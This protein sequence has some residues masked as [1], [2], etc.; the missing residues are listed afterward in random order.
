M[1]ARLLPRPALADRGLV[2]LV[3]LVCAL[4]TVGATGASAWLRTTAD[5]MAAEVFASAKW[6]ARQ[7][8]VTYTDVPPTTV[9]DGAATRLEDALAEPF[10]D[11]LDRPRHAAA[12]VDGLPQAL[13]RRN[14]GGPAYLSVAGIPDVRDQVRVV[15][16]RFP[17]S[18]SRLQ[19]LPRKVAAA[20]DGPRRSPVV[21]VALEQTAAENLN[22][23]TG[24]YVTVSSLRY[25]RTDERAAVLHIVGLYQADVPYPAAI[26]DVPNARRPAIS[27][28][29]EM[30]SVRAAALTAD[31]RTVL[32]TQWRGLPEVV[33]TF[34]P[35]GAPT[36]EEM[37]SLATEA[38]GLAVQPWPAVVDARSASASTGIGDLAEEFLAERGASDALVALALAA[39]A[40]AVVA[41]LLV[42][43][44]VL[45]GR[46][47]DVTDVLRARG[48]STARLLALRGGEAAYLVA[49]GLAVAASLVPPTGVSLLDLGRGAA[50]AAACVALLAVAQVAP[51]RTL[52]ERVRLATRDAL[53]LVVVVLAVGAAILTAQRDRLEATDP[54][55]LALPAL[56]GVAAAVVAVRAVQWGTGVLRRAAA[57]RAGVV[58]VVA[59]SQ[60]SAAAARAVLPVIALVLGASAAMVSVAANDTLHRGAEDA[61]WRAVG[62]DLAVRGSA[63]SPETVERI[64]ALPGTDAVA[65]V[66]TAATATLQTRVGPRR[67][68]VAAVEA[69]ALARVSRGAPERVAVPSSRDE[70]LTVVASSDLDLAGDKTSLSYAGASVPV[71]VAARASTIPGLELSGTFLLVDLEAFRDAADRLVASYDTVLVAGDPDPAS[72]GDVARERS[73][74]ARVETRG[75]VVA[76]VLDAR[77]VDRTLLV[78]RAVAV[79]AVLLA[80]FA[81]MLAVG[82]GRPL[83][84]RT[85]VLLHDLGADVREA[86][87]TTALELVPVVAVAGLA[88]LG[89]GALLTAVLGT[90]VDLA[91]LTGVPVGA[92]VGLDTVS[93]VG[94]GA[95]VAIIL[96]GVA[97]ASARDG[98]KDA[99]VDR[100]SS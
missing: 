54:V 42:A 20:Y 24:T 53:H 48:A 72:V 14:F 100:R 28:L 47:R 80:V 39:L 35:V 11:L 55:L 7:L 66:S 49:P 38:R 41:V 95:L 88:G 81:A 29:P 37:S 1:R 73:P 45:E 10:Q 56:T 79:A 21:E 34:D 69:E 50:A 67:V 86:R 19:R 44:A 77:V 9:P 90:G 25:S 32:Q 63:F 16:G 84:R 83:R 64:A 71:E 27:T 52:P 89:C 82:L 61:G 68:T 6:P 70:A 8:Q 40:A 22:L 12:L 91:A 2:T 76:E 15:E 97:I 94:A 96:V 3:A 5:D 33:W 58:P 51:W 78:V 99:A 60:A 93:W 23:P 74:R 36:A 4:V 13:P 59:L 65:P 62:A 17:R 46:R 98:K 57:G 31:V 43:G 26:D 87:W 85:A 75:A 92:A 30:T 18:G